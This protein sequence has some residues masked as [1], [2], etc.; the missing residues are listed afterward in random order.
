MELWFSSSVNN[1][2]LLLLL[3]QPIIKMRLET[4]FSTGLKDLGYEK[5]LKNFLLFLILNRWE[6]PDAKVIFRSSS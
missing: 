3:A 1:T 2:P 4:V 5:T 6:W